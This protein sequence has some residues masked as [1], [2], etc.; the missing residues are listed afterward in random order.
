MVSTDARVREREREADEASS[1]TRSNLYLSRISS[2]TAHAQW[3]R[4]KT[5]KIVTRKK[6]IL[7]LSAVVA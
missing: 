4:M 2:P 7:L 5:K 3:T 6:E 1:C